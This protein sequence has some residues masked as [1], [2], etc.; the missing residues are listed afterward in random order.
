MTGHY[1]GLRNTQKPGDYVLAHAYVQEDHLLDK[2][3]PAWVPI[4]ALAEIQQ[5]LDKP[6]QGRTEIAGNGFRILSAR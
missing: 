1:A 6:L 5:A 2:I 4:P 3:F